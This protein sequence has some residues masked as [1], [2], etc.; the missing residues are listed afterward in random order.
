MSNRYPHTR[1]VILLVVIAIG[2]SAM[3]R[4]APRTPAPPQAPAPAAQ[5]N[6]GLN[7]SQMPTPVVGKPYRFSLCSGEVLAPTAVSK[8]CGRVTFR[9]QNGSF[10]PPGL[11]LDGFGV[12]SGTTNVDVSKLSVKI[13]A[14]QIGAYGSNFNCQGQPVGFA[15]GKAA[16]LTPPPPPAPVTPPVPP[17]GGVAGAVKGIVGVSAVAIGG[18][19]AY[20]ALKS[21]AACT[22]PAVGANQRACDSGNCSACAAAIAELQP[23][24]DCTDAND[25]AA[26]AGCR[27]AV[28][29]LRGL[30]RQYRCEPAPNATLVPKPVTRR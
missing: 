28:S 26:S 14:I 16:V 23:Y 25:P 11:H 2:S 21:A 22:E 9:L 12:I 10:L 29:V 24:C 4:Q 19:Y 15:G 3:A 1:T 17:G 20:S 27:Q 6:A 8:P 18:A 7:I 13:C 30:E 5:G